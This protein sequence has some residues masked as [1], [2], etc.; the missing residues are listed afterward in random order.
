[1]LV[2]LGGVVEGV[3]KYMCGKGLVDEHNKPDPAKMKEH[4][5]S[6]DFA[7]PISPTAVW[8]MPDNFVTSV[9]RN[10]STA[11]QRL[12]ESGLARQVMGDDFHKAFCTF[13]EGLAK[14][15]SR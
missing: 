5:H 4:I 8:D 12:Q 6:P 7:P 11:L 3:K 10:H 1:M 9:P 13:Y 2:T 15:V 14:G